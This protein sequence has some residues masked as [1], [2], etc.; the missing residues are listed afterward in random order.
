MEI[1]VWHSSD[2]KTLIRF[3]DPNERGKYLIYEDSKVLLITP[4][5]KKPVKLPRSFRLQGSASLDD[6]L[7]LHYSRDFTIAEVARGSGNADGLVKFELINR[8][9]KASYPR[10]QY[11]V[12]VKSGRPTLAEF[13]FASGKIASSI[14]FVAWAPGARL[15]PSVMLLND[16]TRGAATTRIEMLEMERRS[17]PA[18]LFDLDDGAARARLETQH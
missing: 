12:D 1:E 3:L 9:K 11:F 14:K 10:V 7:G 17:I 2:A 15:L 5:A 18:G 16:V 13:Q 4:G 8:H 6:L